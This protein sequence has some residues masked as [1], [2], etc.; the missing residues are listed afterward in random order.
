MSIQS[1]IELYQHQVKT[2]DPRKKSHRKAIWRNMLWEETN[3][4]CVYCG[5]HTPPEF[6]T[7]EHVIPRALG[8]KLHIS[9][10]MPACQICNNHK[11]NEVLPTLY[12]KDLLMFFYVL[13]KE[14]SAHLHFQLTNYKSN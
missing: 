12:C 5:Q 13:A 6:R 1:A 11:P 2:I 8:G 14:T 3:G 7:I 9:N 10:L 4:R